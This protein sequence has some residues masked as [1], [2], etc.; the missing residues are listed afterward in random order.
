MKKV[1]FPI[2]VTVMTLTYSVSDAQTV[3]TNTKST[4][5]TPVTTTT[6]SVPVIQPE[7]VYNYAKVEVRPSYPGGLEAFYKNIQGSIVYPK[8]AVESNLS[9]TVVVKFIIEKDGTITNA[10]IITS[11][12]GGCDEEALKVI[13]KS[14]K[15]NP[16]SIK[17]KPVRVQHMLPIKFGR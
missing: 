10:K 7:E 1:V 13:Q 5:K 3:K 4:S 16:G 8:Q 14:P 2:L 12:G 17:G 15:W 9:G 11:I 6:N